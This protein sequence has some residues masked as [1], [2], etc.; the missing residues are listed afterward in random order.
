[1]VVRADFD[2]RVADAEAALVPADPKTAMAELAA[3]L[4]LVAP[5]G[6]SADDRTEWLKVAHSTIGAYP[7]GALHKACRDVRR[8]C[9][10]VCDIV[11]LVIEMANAE[12]RELRSQLVSAKWARDN[13][14]RVMLPPKTESRP[15]TLDEIVN[16]TEM[17]FDL[18][19]RNGFF[20]PEMLA[21]AE[22]IRAKGAKS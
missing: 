5:S 2:E 7:V 4:T 9:K 6:M 15:F 14:P 19:K 12:A 11:P 16:M 17:V 1:M 10:R 18:G 8:Q 13:P 20:E 21:E 22:R 3:C